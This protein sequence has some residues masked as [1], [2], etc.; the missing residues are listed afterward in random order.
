MHSLVQALTDHDLVILRVIGEWWEL[1]LIGV[2]KAACVRQLAE[3]LAV[4]DILQEVQFLGPEEAAA[5]LD[6]ANHNGRI[7]VAAFERE[8][9]EVRMMGPAALER[10]EPWFDPISPA[11]AL[12]YR[13]FLYRGFAETAEGVIEFFFLPDE[14]IAQFPEPEKPQKIAK[15]AAEFALKPVNQ[16]EKWETAVTHA[17]DDLTTL[18]ALAQ[19]TS[20]QSDKLDQLDDLLL[21][22]DHHRRSLLINLAR[23]MGMVREA[24]AGI[25]PT[26][27]AVSWLQKSREAQL[28]DLADAWTNSGWNDLCHT[29]G[30]ACEGEH[31]HNDP[32]LART[33]LL[34]ALPTTD[35]WYSIADLSQSIKTNDPDFQRPDGN[36]ETWY[37][38]DVVTDV[39]LTGI[40]N[41]DLVEGRVLAF[42]IQGPLFWLGLADTAVSGGK[43]VYRLTDR[44]LEW[45]ANVPAVTKEV[46]V[47]IVVQDDATIIAPHNADRYFRFQVAR[48]SEAEPVQV[49]RPYQYR[50]TPSSLA[51]AKEQGIAVDRILQFLQESSE[52]PLPLS[53]KRGIERWSERGVEAKL[54]TMMILRVREAG[55][56]ETLRSNPK[57]RDYIGQSMGDLA[58]AV[59][60]DH[61]EDLR[62]AAA[63]LGLL[64]DADA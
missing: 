29:P 62:T 41:W 61:W 45:L 52:R 20:L 60:M 49:N 3:R 11:E 55:I 58:A 63:Q 64:L 46:R 50:I 7:P 44:A 34:D 39:Y 38:R 59:R 24:D 17:V 10:E 15:A 40:E 54:E 23:E 35:D 57:T 6:L 47:P 51:S 4:L 5:V 56:L 13:G 14:F 42:L 19:S 18:L 8:H 37:V 1:D 21:N 9:G 30:L 27:T 2:D 22:P 16:P 33:G 48:I 12:W 26:K 32:L 25:R 43:A 28:R 53:T 36:Y 31:W